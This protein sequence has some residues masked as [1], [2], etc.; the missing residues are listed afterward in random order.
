M[1]EVYRAR[2]TK[3]GRD[4]AIK[5]LPE[6]FA[7]NKE[8]L[9]RFEREARLLASLNHPNIGAIHELE[10]SD[11]VH[12]LV[13]EFVPGE[14]LAERIKRGQIPLEEALPLFKQIA[15]GLEAAHEKG[16]IHR[17]LKPA[18][19][20]VTPEGK[21]KVLDFGLAKALAGEAVVQDLSQSPTLTREATELGV[22]LGTAPYMSPEQARGKEVDKKTDI[23]AF[24]CCLYEALTGKTAFL[25]ETVT[26]TIA[27]IVER[28]P[29][30]E[31]IPA[32]NPALV[33]SLLRRCLHKDTSCR[34]H[35][36]AD[37]RIEI[38]E[39]ANEPVAVGDVR[40]PTT[41]LSRKALTY[42]LVALAALAAL[43]V[44]VAVWYLKPPAPRPVT[45]VLAGVEPA[46]W[47]GTTHPG[48]VWTSEGLS[49][50]AMA[51]SPDG[52]HLVYGAGDTEGLHR[53]YLR[54]MDES[55]A[56]PIPGTE[57]AV[58]P[59]FSPSGQWI[60]FWAD[61]NLMKVPID[62]GPPVSLCDAGR[63][64]GASW[65]PND[66]I[67]FGQ[68]TGGI[69]QVS[70]GGGAPEA[71]TTLAEGEWSHRLPHI[72]PDGESILFTVMK[73]DRRWYETKIM[74]KSMETG[75][76]KVLVENGADARYAPTGHLVFA[77][78]G[79]LMAVSFDA[80]RL[81]V[82]GG[83][84]GVIAGVKQAVNVRGGTARDTG[85]AQ[86][87]FS[88]SGSLAYVPGGIFPDVEKSLVWVDREG[89]AE[90]LRA[91]LAPYVYPR[92]APDGKR[93]AVGTLSLEMD[94]WVHD[95]S[96]EAS[97]RLTLEKGRDSSPVWTPDGT[98]ITFNS[99]RTG[100]SNIYWIPADGSGSVERLTTVEPS[101]PASWSPDGQVLAFLHLASEGNYDIWVLP[102]EG[103]PRPFIQS[104]FNET[105]PTFS[106]DGHWLA[107]RSLKSGRSEVY[108]TPFPGPGP[109]HQISTDF[110]RDPAWAPDGRELFYI[111]THGDRSRSMMAVDITTDPTFTAGRP[112]ELFRE[113]YVSTSRLRNYD[114]TPDGRRFL[115]VQDVS[116]PEEVVTELHVVLNWFEEL[117]RLVPTEN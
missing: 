21:V 102:L 114:V 18:N 93:V 40:F 20:K 104:P 26:D 112:R 36:I 90:P 48:T 75:E 109:E 61:G 78:L 46:E 89:A 99:D 24:G 53:L 58:G 111:I 47:L 98:R 39:A 115:M 38:E 68:Q 73:G 63:A 5:V 101:Y 34:L 83:P 64:F 11:G 4:V 49:R 35:D 72:L 76:Q 94:I 71:I 77:R 32:T 25:G 85:A 81:E 8:R 86:F 96:R 84:V 22:L 88:A 70:A 19:I 87:N 41:G 106:P 17:D 30:W 69:L 10:E 16:V 6:V 56:V 51:F 66:T 44:G 42:A 3:L 107:Y 92:L 23:W 33:R 105:H 67:V 108:V 100:R 57:A 74:A 117:K 31:A 116:P 9:A 62:G 13:L 113:K 95:I 52:R 37:A 97:T 103:E 55:E 91:P 45:K 12:F 79:T 50:T 28:E 65:G 82:T 59:F 54:P 2:D 80:A 15:E 7:E 1:G 29:D 60:G 110:G 27:K 43:A 14:T